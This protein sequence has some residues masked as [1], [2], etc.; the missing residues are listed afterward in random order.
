VNAYLAKSG[1]AYL[2]YDLSGLEDACKVTPEG[3]ANACG[4]HIHEGKT[5]DDA[6]A[7][8]G[9]YYATDSDPWG[10]LGYNSRFGKARGSVKAAIG[11]GEDIAGRAIVVHDSTGGRVAC[12]LLPSKLELQEEVEASLPSYCPGSSAS[13]HANAQLTATA[14][15]SCDVVKQEIKDRLAGKNGWY[16]QHNRGTYTEV[17]PQSGVT[18]S[19]TRLTGNGKYTDKMNWVLSGSGNTCNIQTCSESQVFS[20]ADAGANYC[21]TKLLICGSDEG[22]NVANADF[23]TAG[24]QVTKSGGASAGMSNCLKAA[25]IAV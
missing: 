1:N 16:D 2:T 15:A 14:S 8:G 3:V 25:D 18:V 5:C 4:I 23:S 20:I 9:H 6:S 12:A 7:V 11:Q 21:N 17:S 13:I 22:C 19:A 10:A 24:E